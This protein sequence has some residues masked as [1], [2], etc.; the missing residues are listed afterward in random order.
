MSEHK[1]SG[2]DKHSSAVISLRGAFSWRNEESRLRGFLETMTAKQFDES[3]L[4]SASGELPNSLLS[5]H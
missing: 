5:C 2:K 1:Q 3:L 4:K